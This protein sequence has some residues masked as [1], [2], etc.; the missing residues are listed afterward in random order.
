[1]HGVVHFVA[2][3]IGSTA[4]T[5]IF[6]P[7]LA[8]VNLRSLAAN[9]GDKMFCDFPG[10]LVLPRHLFLMIVTY[11]IVIR[12]HMSLCPQ[13]VSRSHSPQLT[14]MVRLA[15]PHGSRQMSHIML[16]LSHLSPDNVYPGL[17][18]GLSSRA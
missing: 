12:E 3:E 4:L 15:T 2:V 6:S 9:I 7:W 5:T 16:A 10:A 8:L 1:M 11:C 17:L 13:P 18:L 14:C